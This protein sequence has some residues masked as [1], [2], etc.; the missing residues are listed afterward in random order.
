MRPRVCAC[1][2]PHACA[3]HLIYGLNGAVSVLQCVCDM[4]LEPCR[5]GVICIAYS[6]HICSLLA[7]SP[8]TNLGLIAS[9]DA[10]S[11]C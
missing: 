2:K 5:L 8:T 3:V 10:K 11:V 4:R 7:Y 9:R 6:V 1:L